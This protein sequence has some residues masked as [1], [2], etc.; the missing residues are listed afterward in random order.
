[1]MLKARSK[2]VSFKKKIKSKSTRNFLSKARFLV[3][4]KVLASLKNL[5]LNEDSHFE[6]E[7]M[8]SDASHFGPNAGLKNNFLKSH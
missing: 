8:K 7:S 4:G 2:H 5:I 3:D 1:M 6:D